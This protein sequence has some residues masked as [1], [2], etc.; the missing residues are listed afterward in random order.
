MDQI[1]INMLKT[2]AE[3][4]K[5]NWK[6]HI[7]KKVHAY[8]CTNYFSTGYL[9]CHY[10]L[11]GRTTKLPIDLT[12]PS[13]AVDQEQTTHSSYVDEWKEQIMQAY[14]IANKQS[15]QRKSIILSDKILRD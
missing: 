4:N 3:R 1:I 11:F 7:Q 15:I 10:L 2:L 6:G 5:S 8:N 14:E 12:T 9:P 13:L